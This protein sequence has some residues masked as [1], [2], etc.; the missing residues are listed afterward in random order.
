MKDLYYVKWDCVVPKGVHKQGV[1][2]HQ[3]DKEEVYHYGRP[4]FAESEKEAIEKVTKGWQN[5]V[6]KQVRKYKEVERKDF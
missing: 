1:V 6:V 5:V 4:V 3:V 2:E